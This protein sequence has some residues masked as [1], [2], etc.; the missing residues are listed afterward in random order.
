MISGYAAQVVLFAASLNV[1]TLVGAV[2]MFSSVG[3]MA[4]VQPRADEDVSV[5]TDS[6]AT[7]VAEAGV[8]APQLASEDDENE[9]LASFIASEFA[10]PA[11]RDARSSPLRMRRSCV[12][13]EP[14]AKTIGSLA[15]ASVVSA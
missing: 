4:L 15:L 6:D 14:V 13:G 1:H 9:S 7:E 10:S 11:P 8:V 3:I 5:S 2:C 12:G